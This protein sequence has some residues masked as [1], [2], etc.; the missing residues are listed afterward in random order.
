MRYYVVADIHGYSKELITELNAKGFFD[1][2]GP[3]K[4]IICGDIYDRG[5][6][7]LELQKFILEL[8][9]QDKVILIK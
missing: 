5:K 3:Y 2:K 1:D 8:L 9:S 6:E 7:A 4:L